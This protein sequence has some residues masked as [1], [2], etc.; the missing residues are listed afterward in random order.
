MG[1][2][3]KGPDFSRLLQYPSPEMKKRIAEAAAAHAKPAK[4]G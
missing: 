3:E 2:D 1:W 4:A